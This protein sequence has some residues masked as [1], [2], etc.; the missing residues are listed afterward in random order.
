MYEPL[1]RWLSDRLKSTRAGRRVLVAL[2]FALVHV[3]ERVA[4]AGVVDRAGG[5]RRAR[6]LPSRLMTVGSNAVI[7]PFAAASAMRFTVRRCRPRRYVAED[8]VCASGR[9]SVRVR[10]ALDG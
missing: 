10:V 4:G 1:R 9:S 7:W 5:A 6:I 2:A 8:A 3:L